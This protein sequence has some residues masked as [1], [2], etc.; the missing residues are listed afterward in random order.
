[1][2]IAHRGYSLVELLAALAVVAIICLVTVPAFG[3]MRR[4]S[5][6]RLASYDL[7]TIFHQTRSRAIARNRNA[8]VRFTKIA[9][10]WVFAVYDDGD[11]DGVRNDDITR[12]TDRLAVP[13]RRVLRESTLATIGLL[14]Q[15]VTDPDGDRLLPTASPVQFN[16]S[17]LCS[18]SPLGESTPGT[19]YITDRAGELYA[20]R[21]Y[22]ATAKMRVL[23]Y[24]GGRRRWEAR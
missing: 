1:M 5:A 24:D 6:V 14:P 3:S 2:R 23:R 22:G 16:A 19:I 12:G 4:R 9:S 18:F 17:Q 15:T 20:V 7:R 13:A 11:G 21:V 8:G 10:G